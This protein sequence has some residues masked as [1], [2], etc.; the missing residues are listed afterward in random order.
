MLDG[1][2]HL[3][4]VHSSNTCDVHTVRYISTVLTQILGL[5]KPVLSYGHIFVRAV[6]EWRRDASIPPPRLS[7]WGPPGISTHCP[8]QRRVPTLVSESL[9]RIIIFSSC[10]L[11]VGPTMLPARCLAWPMSVCD[12]P[13]CS[14]VVVVLA[15]APPLAPATP[16]IILFT[17]Q[18]VPF[19]VPA[20]AAPVRACL[21]SSLVIGAT[22]HSAAKHLTAQTSEI[23]TRT[24][25][26]SCVLR[27]DYRSI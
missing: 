19:G 18:R 20:T 26:K 8:T 6:S 2:S 3:H 22:C 5:S 21:A 25:I 9:S 23:L 11:D 14:D 7:A 1:V 12:S 4:R 13:G 10:R 24:R 16:R 27:S 15:V 17:R